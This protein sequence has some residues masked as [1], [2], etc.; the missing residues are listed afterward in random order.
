[1]V[2]GRAAFS[3][4]RR[5]P[6]NSVPGSTDTAFSHSNIREINEIRGPLLGTTTFGKRDLPSND[7]LAIGLNAEPGRARRPGFRFQESGVRRP[8]HQDATALARGR[9]CGPAR[10]AGRPRG[11]AV[12]CFNTRVALLITRAVGSMWCAYIIGQRIQADLSGQPFN[13]RAL[14]SPGRLPEPR[15]SHCGPSSPTRQLPLRRL[16]R[17]HPRRLE[18]TAAPRVPDLDESVTSCG[19]RRKLIYGRPMVR[20]RWP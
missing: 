19:R 1:M 11:T 6:D 12:T 8:L 20:W 3:G 18:I 2:P 15:N 7:D 14:I 16:R 10:L 9:W 17:G 5:L 13:Q 4:P